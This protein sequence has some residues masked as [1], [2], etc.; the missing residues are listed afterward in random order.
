MWVSGF[1]KI[2]NGYVKGSNLNLVAGGKQNLK[3][4]VLKKDHR[5]IESRDNMLTK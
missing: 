3:D 2:I 1:M 4:K 5:I